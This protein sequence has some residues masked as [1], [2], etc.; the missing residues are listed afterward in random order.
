MTSII[1]QNNPPK[2][3]LACRRGTWCHSPDCRWPA[4]TTSTSV[5]PESAD[6]GRWR[7]SFPC[8]GWK[9]VNTIL[10]NM[11]ITSPQ[12]FILDYG[13]LAMA[14]NCKIGQKVDERS[15]CTP[16]LTIY[17]FGHRRLQRFVICR[18]FGHQPT[19]EC[20]SLLFVVG[21]VLGADRTGD[22]LKSTITVDKVFVWL[23]I[24]PCYKP[25][26]FNK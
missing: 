12:H 5:R 26:T 22:G 13:H 25:N 1:Y 8:P 21:V 14:R 16:N 2:Y 9:N 23:I 11:D 4:V 24:Y 3:R 17:V 7:W 18:P 19:D 15:R 20:D 10:K 6:V